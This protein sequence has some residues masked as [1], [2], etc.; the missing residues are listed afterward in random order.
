MSNPI[1]FYQ[2]RPPDKVA[3][4][5]TPKAAEDDPAVDKG[6]KADLAPVRA[7]QLPLLPPAVGIR[8][9]LLRELP[10][11]LPRTRRRTDS[12]SISTAPQQRD[13]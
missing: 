7:P 12:A 4:A 8:W 2:P 11:S 1:Y 13:P 10:N 3:A 5:G 6:A 9:D